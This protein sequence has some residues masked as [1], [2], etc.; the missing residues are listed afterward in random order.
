[1]ILYLAR[2]GK[3][4]WNVEHRS[5]GWKDIPLNEEGLLQARE[6]AEKLKNIDFETIYSSDLKR[7]KKTADIICRP[8]YGSVRTALSWPAVGL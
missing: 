8:V 3:T 1:M 7:S 5:Q 2:H 6:L 4:A